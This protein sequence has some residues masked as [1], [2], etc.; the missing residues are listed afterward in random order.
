MLEVM[1]MCVLEVNLAS[2]P[3]CK[4]AIIKNL[5]QNIENVGV[6]FFFI[7]QHYTVW[8]ASDLFGQL[9]AFIPN[10]TRRRTDQSA[11]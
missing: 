3:V 1:M 9:P 6:S 5:Q 2:E 7:E 8:F 4:L 10:I 11:H